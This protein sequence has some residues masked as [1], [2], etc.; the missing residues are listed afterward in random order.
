MKVT[1][2]GKAAGSSVVGLSRTRLGGVEETMKLTMSQAGKTETANFL[3]VIA[4]DGTPLL[5][6]ME[7]TDGTQTVSVRA[8]YGPQGVAVTAKFGGRTIDRNFPYPA[9]ATIKAPSTFW[10]LSVR[11]KKGASDKYS[12]FDVQTLK[13]LLDEDT[14]LGDE[15]IEVGG[16][17]VTAHKEKLRTG[18]EW[19]DDHGL[20]Y[21]FV[22]NGKNTIVAERS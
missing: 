3:H 7:A 2:G 11:P 16:R 17:K 18:I 5:E 22:I 6:T 19:L 8:S 1:V 21:R 4:K 13:W 12:H 15:T 9:G 20:P 10:F 14:Y